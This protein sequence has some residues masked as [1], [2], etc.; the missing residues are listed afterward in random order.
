MKAYTVI[1][2][3]SGQ[4]GCVVTGPLAGARLLRHCVYHSPTGFET[5]YAGSG[6]ADLA[7]SILADYYDATPEQV[8]DQVNEWGDEDFRHG[9]KMALLYHQPFKFQ[10]ITPRQLENGES[11]EITFEQI[12]LFL[13]GLRYMGS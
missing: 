10:F 1:R 3:T 5:G 6:P 4:V 11:Y 8:R 2:S 13:R 12:S 9:A 7:L